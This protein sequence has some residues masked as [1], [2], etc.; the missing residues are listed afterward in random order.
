MTNSAWLKMPGLFVFCLQIKPFGDI[1]E[2]TES[3]GGIEYGRS[4]EG[5]GDR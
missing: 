1:I 3:G 4:H 2:Q 5:Y